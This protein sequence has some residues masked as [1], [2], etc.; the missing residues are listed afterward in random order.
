MG[1]TEK[2]KGKSYRGGGQGE[3]QG[4]KT[5]GIVLKSQEFG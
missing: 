4:L 3:V 2:K 1:K 5:L